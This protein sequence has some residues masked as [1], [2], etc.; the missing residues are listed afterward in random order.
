MKKVGS[1]QF[2]ED[3]DLNLKFDFDDLA[4]FHGADEKGI[5]EKL[6]DE[7]GHIKMDFLEELVEVYVNIHIKEK[8]GKEFSLDVMD[9]T[10]D[11]S[12]NIK[13]ESIKKRHIE[14]WWDK[15]NS[16]KPKKPKS[17][18]VEVLEGL[19]RDLTEQLGEKVTVADSVYT[20]SNKLNLPKL[21]K[22]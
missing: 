13:V 2:F 7:N 10:M 3:V 21:K 5:K 18:K 1:L 12:W 16:P 4:K 17:S 22:V 6:L 14:E 15:E 11:I 8:Y 9:D 19:A 20:N